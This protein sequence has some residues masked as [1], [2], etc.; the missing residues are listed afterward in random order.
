MTSLAVRRDVLKWVLSLNLSHSI[1]NPKRDFSNGFLIAE[2]F[3]KYYPQDIQMHSFDTGTA[4]AKKKDNW[5]LLEKF[6]KKRKIG[7]ISRAEIDKFIEMDSD[8]ASPVIEKLHALLTK[9]G[10]AGAEPKM[11][12]GRENKDPA[13][14][15]R[16]SPEPAKGGVH[17][18][19]PAGGGPG[20]GAALYLG[21]LVSATIQAAG[22]LQRMAHPSHMHQPSMPYGAPHMAPPGGGA[23]GYHPP[24]AHFAPS[25]EQQPPAPAY[26]YNP[27]GPPT[28]EDALIS[29]NLPGLEPGPGPDAL[30]KMMGGLGGRGRP[31]AYANHAPRAEQQVHPRGPAPCSRLPCARCPE[32]PSHAPPRRGL[33]AHPGPARPIRQHI[34]HPIDAC[35]PSRAPGPVPSMH[36]LDAWGLGEPGGKVAPAVAL[37]NLK[38]LHSSEQP[39]PGAAGARLPQR[40]SHGA[41]PTAGASPCPSH[42][43]RPP[44]DW[45]ST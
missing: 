37:R 45:L 23:G 8:V 9:H 18:A 3:S 15:S 1:K 28:G 41:L 43:P 16:A 21:S 38:H 22:E 12:V 30:D 13:A 19:V 17:P 31:D 26:A 7:A 24:P 29:W 20:R 5:A 11:N 25:Q 14:P 42:F 10:S 2:I 33:A 39:L 36:Q 32:R 35:A 6:M 40:P 44:A 4:A 27:V 34:L